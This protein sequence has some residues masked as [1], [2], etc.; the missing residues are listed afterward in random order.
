MEMLGNTGVLTSAQAQAESLR[1]LIILLFPFQIVNHG[2]HPG[3]LLF[4]LVQVLVQMLQLFGRGYE[5]PPAP[6][7]AAAVMAHAVKGTTTVAEAPALTMLKAM[8]TAVSVASSWHI[9]HNAYLLGVGAFIPL[10]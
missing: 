3:H 5:A 2:L 10:R 4:E 9:T 1:P 6:A 8:T 7:M